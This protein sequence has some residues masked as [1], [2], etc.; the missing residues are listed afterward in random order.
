[1]DL[2][3]LLSLLNFLSGFFFGFVAG[4]I[5]FTIWWLRKRRLIEHLVD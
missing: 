4:S 1:M 3:Q 2:L 5:L